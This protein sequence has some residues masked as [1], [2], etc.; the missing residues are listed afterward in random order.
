[1]GYPESMTEKTSKRR[2]GDNALEDYFLELVIKK[3]IIDREIHDLLEITEKSPLHPDY[4]ILVKRILF[5]ES[6]IYIENWGT[7]E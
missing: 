2:G 1:M 4:Q 3:H 7:L 6:N 5:G